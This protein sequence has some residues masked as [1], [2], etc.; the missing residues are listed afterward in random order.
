VSHMCHV[1]P[2]VAGN[3]AVAHCTSYVTSATY[4]TPPPPYCRAAPAESEAPKTASKRDRSAVR[5]RRI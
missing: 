3:D 4:C 1:K 2:S 5:T